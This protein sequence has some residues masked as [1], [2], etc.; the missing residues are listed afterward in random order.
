MCLCVVYVYVE[1]SGEYAYVTGPE[2]LA[3]FSR[4]INHLP[5]PLSVSLPPPLWVSPIPQLFVPL[6]PSCGPYLAPPCRQNHCMGELGR[7]WVPTYHNCL[8]IFF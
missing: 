4:A 2:I 6:P 3:L 8:V 7:V 1:G 5:T